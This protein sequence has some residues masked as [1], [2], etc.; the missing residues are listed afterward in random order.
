M[1][2]AL[3]VVEGSTKGLTTMYPDRYGDDNKLL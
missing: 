2:E 1:K 3:W